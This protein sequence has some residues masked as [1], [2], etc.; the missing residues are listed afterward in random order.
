MTAFEPINVPHAL[1][2][3][4]CDYLLLDKA[5]AFADYAKSELIEGEIWVVN[6]IHSWHARIMAM[7]VRRIGNALELCGSSLA[8]YAPV[9]IAMS[10]DS[11]PEPDIAVGARN[12]DGIL[13]LDKLLLVIEVADTTRDTDLGKKARLYARH[14]VAEYWVV[15]RD[16]GQIVQMTQPRDT[17]YA[18]V[19]EIPFGKALTSKTITGLTIQTDQFG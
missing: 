14:G 11:V 8:V 18:A 10:D 16:G 4:A 6:A 12:E 7:L 3:R 13:P 15:D 1:K 5:G 17:G 19:T 9:S 2:L